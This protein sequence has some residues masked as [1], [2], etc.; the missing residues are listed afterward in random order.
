MLLFFFSFF[1]S[2]SSGLS[3]VYEVVV[4]DG[5]EHDSLIFFKYNH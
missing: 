2:Y 4:W 3:L 1:Q 5:Y